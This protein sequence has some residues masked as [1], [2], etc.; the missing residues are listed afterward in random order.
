[1]RLIAALAAPISICV[2]ARLGIRR[3]DTR[4]RFCVALASRA[5]AAVAVRSAY[6]LAWRSGPALGTESYAALEAA[7]D[8]ALLE[9][10][11]DTVP[12]DAGR[13]G[14]AFALPRHAVSL[15]VLDFP[16]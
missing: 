14:L 1:M 11:P 15:L 2:R 10:T 12:L 4:L 9:G 16:G 13:G 8:L 7:S 5:R 3:G 6:G